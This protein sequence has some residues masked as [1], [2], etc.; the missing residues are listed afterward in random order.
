MGNLADHLWLIKEDRPLRVFGP[1]FGMLAA[2]SI[3]LAW[4]LFLTYLDT[5]LVPRLPTAVLSTALML[6]VYQ[7][8]HCLSA[9]GVSARTQRTHS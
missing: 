3:A 8:R 1:V 7:S 2:C 9:R 6:V 4:L 5:G